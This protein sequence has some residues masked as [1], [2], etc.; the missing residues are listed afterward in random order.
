MSTHYLEQALGLQITANQ[1]TVLGFRSTVTG[2]IKVIT[3]W[4]RD[5]VSAD[6]TFDVNKGTVNSDLTTLFSGTKPKILSGSH[7][8]INSGLSIAVTA[9]DLITLDI[10]NING[11]TLNLLSFKVEIDD[12]VSGA[13]AVNTQSFTTVGTATWTNPTGSKRVHVIVIGAGGGG[14]G[15]IKRATG[16]SRSAGGGGGG[17]AYAEAWFD[18]TALGSTETVTVGAGG[19]GGAGITTNDGAFGNAGSKGGLSSFGNWLKAEGGNGASATTGGGT[20][21]GGAAITGFPSFHTSGIGGTGGNPTGSAPAATIF[22]PSGGG[23]GGGIDTSNTITSGS[24][25]GA[26]GVTT[27]S[28]TGSGQNYP[29]AGGTGSA[30]TGQSGGT[31]NTNSATKCGSGGG[32]GNSSSTTNGGNGGTGGLYGGGGGGAGSANNSVGN[33]GTGGTGGQ[34][35]VVVTTYF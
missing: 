27:G 1:V 6:V 7:E 29:L 35:I 14:G 4:A 33:G 5:N 20:N 8:G 3:I 10:D 31:G 21:T 11:N 32:G 26:I 16:T 22:P 17:G 30:S 12:G 23:G 9:G 24:A 25:G 18:A 19:A 15:G 2:T 34:G 28:N 13:Q